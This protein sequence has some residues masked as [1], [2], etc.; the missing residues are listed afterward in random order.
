MR[1]KNNIVSIIE[2]FKIFNSFLEG[3]YKF[4]FYLVVF[5]IVIQSLLEVLGIGIAIPVITSIIDPEKKNI[6]SFVLDY[7]MIFN[8]HKNANIVTLLFFVCIFF[9]FKS[10][11]L[12]LSSKKIYN[13]SHDL[14]YKIRERIFSSYIEMEYVEYLKNKSEN[15]ISNISINVSQLTAYFTTPM[16][17]FLAE[18]FILISILILLLIFEPVGFFIVLFL[19]GITILIS[20]KTLS[21]KLKKIGEERQLLESKFVKIINNSIGSIKVTKLY[22]LEKKYISEFDS[23][24]RPLNNLQAD[25][26]LYSNIPRFALEFI[27]LL[28]ICCI[29][30]FLLFLNVQNTHI[31][32]TL[33]LFAAAGFKIIPGINRIIFSIQS[34]KYSSSIVFTINEMLLDAK[35]KDSK[36]NKNLYLE[37]QKLDFINELQIKNLSYVYPGS[38]SRVINNLNFSIKKGMKIGLEGSSGAGKTTFLDVITG[39]VQPTT[40]EILLD[41]KTVSLNNITWRNTIAYVPQFSFLIDDTIEANIAFG[42]S[43][44]KLDNN[45]INELLSLTFLKEELSGRDKNVSKI[46]VGE[47]GINLSG[48]QIQRIGIARA[49]YKRPKILILDEPTSSLDLKTEKNV[50]DIIFNIPNLTLIIVSH[51]KTSLEKCDKIYK[52]SEGKLL[53]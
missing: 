41:G 34:I 38:T 37:K 10:Y 4:K 14:Q 25:Q 45:L 15:F 8:N 42:V 29:V 21:K 53:I 31:I 24:N 47:R 9:A 48:G 50:I 16:L 46:I 20:Y 5:L 7:F 52:L 51:R 49:L 23:I 13:F 28:S 30:F 6:L 2:K 22:N 33:A 17:N 32:T 44:S 12:Y 1:K 26:L 39:L 35:D 11:F 36:N 3:K 43:N 27:S 19:L 18:V 40:G